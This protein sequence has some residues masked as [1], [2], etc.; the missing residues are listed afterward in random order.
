MF[1]TIPVTGWITVTLQL[2]LF[3]LPSFAVAVIVAV[4]TATAVTLPFES[5]VATDVLEDFHVTALLLALLGLT[6]TVK[7]SLP[8]TFM[9]VP[10]LFNEIP[11]TG[12]DTV[13]LQVA[14]FPLPSLAVAVIVAV[15]GP[16]AVTLPFES[17]VATDVLEDFHVNV[18]LVALSGLT[19]AVKV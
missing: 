2:A 15:P 7:V 12:W 14:L 4:P 9:L 18:L 10:V 16:T 6:V 3:P 19:V 11:V 5:T 1:N 8:P 17:T 13:T